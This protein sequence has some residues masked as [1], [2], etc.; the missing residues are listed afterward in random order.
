MCSVVVVVSVDKLSN[1]D[2]CRIKVKNCVH[3]AQVWS[4]IKTTGYTILC[5]NAKIWSARC[6]F[7]F[8]VRSVRIDRSW[9][10]AGSSSVKFG[11][12]ILFSHVKHK[13]TIWLFYLL[14]ACAHFQ[15]RLNLFFFLSFYLSLSMK[16]SNTQ[17]SANV[18]VD[19]E[20]IPKKMSILIW[21]DC[22]VFFSV[23]DLFCLVGIHCF[24]NRFRQL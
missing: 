1:C 18:V 12:C 7:S 23:F 20:T 19:A 10:L 4:A 24:S 9:F 6:S 15:F 5:D 3:S 16:H 22:C 13:L 11:F 2:D 8:S 17:M 21:F 14:R